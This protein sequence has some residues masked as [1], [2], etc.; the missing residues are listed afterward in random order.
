[1][2]NDLAM[3]GGGA[4][5]NVILAVFNLLP[6][7]PLDVP[8]SVNRRFRENRWSGDRD[9]DILGRQSCTRRRAAGDRRSSQ[10]AVRRRA[11]HPCRSGTT[12]QYFIINQ[13]ISNCTFFLDAPNPT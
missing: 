7:P 11:I 6:L 12:P 13:S 5:I 8:V 10:G 2:S 3:I 4:F 9:Q 1:M